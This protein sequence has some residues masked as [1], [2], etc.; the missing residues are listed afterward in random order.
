MLLIGKREK[1]LSRGKELKEKE[2]GGRER[3]LGVGLHRWITQAVTRCHSGLLDLQERK[4]DFQSM[5]SN[6]CSIVN[7][8]PNRSWNDPAVK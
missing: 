1:K 2:R 8:A 3:G 7:K 4:H 5:T 6:N